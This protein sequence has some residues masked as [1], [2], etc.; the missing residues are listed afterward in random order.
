M[1][2][3]IRYYRKK[4]FILLLALLFFFTFLFVVALVNP[5]FNLIDIGLPNG[6]ENIIIVVF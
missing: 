6:V 2:S 4:V 5:N 3:M 1:K